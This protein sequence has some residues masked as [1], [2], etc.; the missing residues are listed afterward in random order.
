MEMPVLPDP[1]LT[2][3]IRSYSTL[4]ILYLES[5]ENTFSQIVHVY[6]LILGAL[7]EPSSQGTLLNV[8]EVR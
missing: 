8:L 2:I 1:P 3:H 6:S 7:V 4:D 5:I